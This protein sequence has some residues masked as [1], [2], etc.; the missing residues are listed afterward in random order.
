MLGPS[1]NEVGD[2]L[3]GWVDTKSRGKVRR[4]GGRRGGENGD[5]DCMVR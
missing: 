3:A 2:K 5:S 1:V 4:Q